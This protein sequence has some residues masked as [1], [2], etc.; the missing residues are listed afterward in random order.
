MKKL[1]T[2]S[3]LALTFLGA[4]SVA[5]AGHCKKPKGDVESI[6]PV[7]TWQDGQWAFTVR[8]EVE[9]KHAQPGDRFDLVLEAQRC[10]E[11]VASSDG[12]P[13]VV[14]IPLTI[15]ERQCKSESKFYNEYATQVNPNLLGDPHGMKV[16]AKLIDRASGK[17]LDDKTKKVKVCGGPLVVTQVQVPIYQPVSV[18][19]HP[20]QPVYASPPAPAPVFVTPPG[21]SRP[22]VIYQPYPPGAAAYAPS[23]YPI[24]VVWSD[25]GVFV[26][27]SCAYPFYRRSCW[28][29]WR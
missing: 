24:N 6:K 28:G 27:P 26:D 13:Y 7:L 15:P 14:S 16:C 20:P 29:W 4:G 18:V 9:I 17:M 3:M 25:G 8:Y 2:V 10:G 21:Y 23:G 1:L 11:P 19:T 22:A 5:D 12:Q